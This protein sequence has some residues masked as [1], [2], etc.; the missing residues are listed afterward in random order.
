MTIALTARVAAYND[1]AKAQDWPSL[2]DEALAFESKILIDLL[3]AWRRQAG[4]AIPRRSAMSARALKPHLG[5]V[6]IIERIARR[7]ARFQMRLMGTRLT[8]IVGDLQGRYLDE[9]VPSDLVVRWNAALDLTLAETRP[10]RFVNRV[11]FKGLNFLRAEILLAPL[12]GGDETPSMV[13]GGAV[14]TATKRK[15]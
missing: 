11:D 4:S 7:P 6:A 2:C 14:F 8:Q 3:A 12:L 15:G 10:L 1:F 13:L 5:N 9:A